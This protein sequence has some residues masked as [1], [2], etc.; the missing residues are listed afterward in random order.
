MPR[1]S[2]SVRAGAR[3]GPGSAWRARAWSSG[4]KRRW[5]QKGL[6]G[7]RPSG[8]RW[9]AKRKRRRSATTGC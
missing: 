6:P 8:A 5:Q 1:Q 3:G 2:T 9:A 4:W 7:G